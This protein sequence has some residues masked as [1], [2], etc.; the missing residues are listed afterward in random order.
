MNVAVL[1]GRCVERTVVKIQSVPV[2]DF[3]YFVGLDFSLS[4]SLISSA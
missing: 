4:F 3:P 2:K 1:V